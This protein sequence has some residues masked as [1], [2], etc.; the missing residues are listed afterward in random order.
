MSEAHLPR[1]RRSASLTP[2]IV[3]PADIPED[4]EGRVEVLAVRAPADVIDPGEY[5]PEPPPAQPSRVVEA[6]LSH[7]GWIAV[8]GLAAAIVIL[9]V[10]GMTLVR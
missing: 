8:G 7:G 5:P 2:A 9:F 4:A 6:L 3:D 10:L 1:R